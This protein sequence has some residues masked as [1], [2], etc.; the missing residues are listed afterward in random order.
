[1]FPIFPVGPS[2]CIANPHRADVPLTP[3][4]HHLSFAAVSSPTASH[5]P[6]DG[7][8]L[9]PRSP[10]LSFVTVPLPPSILHPHTTCSSPVMLPLLPRVQIHIVPPPLLYHVPPQDGQPPQLPRLL[11]TSRFFLRGQ[12]PLW[13]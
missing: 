7:V 6:C 13:P 5:T 1:M 11:F 12:E 3:R 2:A 8:P 9:L 4:T 10:H